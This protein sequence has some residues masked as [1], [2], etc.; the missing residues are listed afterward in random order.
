MN[1]VR[2]KSLLRLI[3]GR[4]KQMKIEDVELLTGLSAKTIHFYE[5]QRLIDVQ[6]DTDGNNEYEE[7]HISE[8]QRLKVLNRLNISVSKIKELNDER[9]T[10]KELLESSLKELDKR[11]LVLD[12]KKM[13]IEVILKDIKKK[14]QVDFGKYSK[15]LDYIDNQEFSEQLGNLKRLGETSL[16]QQII[17]SLILSG[18]LLWFFFNISINNY[19]FIVVESFLSI[20]STIILT[21]SWQKFLKQPNKKIKGTGAILLSLV[22]T[23]VLVLGIY[24]GINMLQ[25]VLFVPK[26]Y[27]MY[28]FKEPYIKF[29]F[30]FEFEV[31]VI[32]GFLVYKKIKVIQWQWTNDLY[33]YAKKHIGAITILNV[34]LLYICIT[35]ITVVT[36]NKIT[37]YNF[38]NIIGTNYSYDDIT[39]VEA[40][41]KGRTLNT[42]KGE[43]GEFYYFVT[44]N[45][46]NKKNFYGASGNFEDTYLELEMF[47]KLIMGTGK[48]IK[49]S[50]SDNYEF[51][52]FDQKYIDRFLRIIENR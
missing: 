29:I 25:L 51:C 22:F 42:F 38:Y 18:P 11:E 1:S 52:N 20:I 15:D 32:L 26:D 6:Q 13:A 27:L 43:A 8:L 47:D 30:F 28:L 5:K 14:Q 9:I 7:Y 35:G 44:F 49:E 17:N 16:V 48:V 46:G 37:D 31:L 40:G 2:V 23:L 36:E 33:V 24:I 50:S 3:S 34:V 21:L 12:Y 45:D 10:L 39:K 19:D 41:F 4:E